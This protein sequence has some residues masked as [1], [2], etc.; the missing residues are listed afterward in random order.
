MTKVMKIYAI[1]KSWKPRDFVKKT[2]NT[3]KFD[4]LCHP[5]KA[6]NWFAS[7]QPCS[8]PPSLSSHTESS[9]CQRTGHA[10]VDAP[11]AWD[12]NKRK[13]S[14]SFIDILL[15]S[16]SKPISLFLM[17]VCI[18]SNLQMYYKVTTFYC[19]FRLF[20][21]LCY[22]PQCFNGNTLFFYFIMSF[23]FILRSRISASNYIHIWKLLTHTV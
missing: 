22:C 18:W 10:E 20:P 19:T 9:E 1:K 13:G 4:L 17:A 15:F 5:Q 12:L 23:G 7:E 16:K 21:R 8:K 2:T 11:L 14:T 3:W 6:E